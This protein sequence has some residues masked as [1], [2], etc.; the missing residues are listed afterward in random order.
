M[1]RRRWMLWV[2]ATLAVAILVHLVTVRAIPRLITAR[3]LKRMA[4]LNTMHFGRRPD[5]ASRGVVRPSPDLLY[6]SCPYDLSK[7]PL[8]V[9][10]RVPHS[11]YWSVS[12]FDAAS[13]NFFVR[14][15]QQIAG[16]SIEILALRPGMTPPTSGDAHQPL[17]VYSPTRK[18]LFL[19]RLLIDDDAHLAILDALRH[20][21]SC[22]SVTTA[23]NSG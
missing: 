11:T 5:E 4:P 9:T 1:K 3:V 15:D 14:N 13:N 8:R 19:F 21:A 23:G 22:A 16:D 6:S 20:E 12:A 7:G 2:G 10:A 18:G 17:I